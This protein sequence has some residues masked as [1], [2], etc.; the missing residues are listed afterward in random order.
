MQDE[1]RIWLILADCTSSG[2]LML[3]MLVHTPINEKYVAAPINEKYVAADEKLYLHDDGCLHFKEN[4]V[5]FK[6]LWPSN[7]SES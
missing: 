4:F 3:L 7:V 6:L 1:L 2:L 5:S